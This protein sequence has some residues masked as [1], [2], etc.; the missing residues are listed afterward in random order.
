[1]DYVASHSPLGRSGEPEGIAYLTKALL[2]GKNMHT[3]GETI[4]IAGGYQQSMDDLKFI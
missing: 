1:M 4:M 2:D 3:T